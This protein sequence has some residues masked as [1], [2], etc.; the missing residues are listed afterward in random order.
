M[1]YPKKIL[2]NS[3]Q[4]QSRI[5]ADRKEQEHLSLFPLVMRILTMMR[6]LA[7]G[8]TKVMCSTNS[9]SKRTVENCVW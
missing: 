3:R 9:S 6:L 7:G 2:V 4:T 5:Q 1:W 8:E